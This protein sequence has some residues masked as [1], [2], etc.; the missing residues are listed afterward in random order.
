MAFPR[1]PLRAP[2]PV[3]TR[4]AVFAVGRR[5]YVAAAGDLAGRVTLTDDRNSPRAGVRD[6]DEVTIVAW[7][8][9]WEGRTRY[10]V[11]VAHSDL[12]GWL[13]AGNLRST[14]LPISSP[15]VAWIADPGPTPAFVTF[16]FDSRNVQIG[17]AHV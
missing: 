4:A 3:R 9:G 11:R 17:R 14:K 15:P 2:A 12:E 6:G 10:C 1:S 13:L 5:V 16:T 7:R 8:P